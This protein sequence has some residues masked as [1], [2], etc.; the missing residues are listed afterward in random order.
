MLSTSKLAPSLAL[1]R[2][3]GM[4][5]TCRLTNEAELVV[6][7]PF[8]NFN[9]AADPVST[10]VFFYLT[11]TLSWIIRGVGRVTSALH[12]TGSRPTENPLSC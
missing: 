4:R 1:P 7:K 11:L 12:L 9:L 2:G 8:C 6:F 10:C 5:Q 3:E